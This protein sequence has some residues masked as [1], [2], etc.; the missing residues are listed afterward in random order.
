MKYKYQQYGYHEFYTDNY[1]DGQV[2]LG[3]INEYIQSMGSI[4]VIVEA[5]IQ[6]NKWFSAQ[7]KHT[8]YQ[9]TQ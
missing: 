4:T 2:P 5:I 6:W 3:C 7:N 8:E 1:E 9:Q